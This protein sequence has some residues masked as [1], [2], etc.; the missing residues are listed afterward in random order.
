MNYIRIFTIISLLITSSAI[1]GTLIE[2]QKQNSQITEADLI[3]ESV[4]DALNQIEL[5]TEACCWTIMIYLSA[6]NDLEKYAIRDIKEMLEG[7][8]NLPACVKILVQIDRHPSNN[9]TAGYSGEALP[10]EAAEYTGARRY[11]IKNG[12]LILKESRGEVDMSKSSEL[13]NFTTWAIKQSPGCSK[14]ALI[15]WNH[16]SGDSGVGVDE[17]SG[18][19]K[20]SLKAVREALEKSKQDTN[21]SLDLL[22]FDACH[23]A[24]ASVIVEME[25]LT[26]VMVGSEEVEPGDG[27]DYKSLFKEIGKTKGDLSERT[28]GGLIVD[29][30]GKFYKSTTRKK[31]TLSS[32]DMEYVPKFKRAFRD[33]S[34]KL[35]E[36]IKND[37]IKFQIARA[38]EWARNHTYQFKGGDQIDLYHFL[39]QLSRVVDDPALLRAIDDLMNVILRMR[40]HVHRGE[41]APDATGVSIWFKKGSGFTYTYN[42]ASALKINDSSCWDPLI[43]SFDKIYKNATY[44]TWLKTNPANVSTYLEVLGKLYPKQPVQDKPDN[45]QPITN[46]DLGIDLKP[47]KDDA[48]LDGW[49]NIY[50]HIPNAKIFPYPVHTIPIENV[51]SFTGTYTYQPSTSGWYQLAM[52]YVPRN[53]SSIENVFGNG[54]NLW[55]SDQF[56]V[57]P[58]SYNLV[59]Y[60]SSSYWGRLCLVLC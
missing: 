6:D 5:D 37:T 44:R 49:I 29:T 43:S 20:L 7:S 51:S 33:F 50:E 21:Q 11:E 28:L 19:R 39:K 1:T 57:A 48:V 60:P 16:G 22:G 52:E 8:K 13:R 38:I 15:I 9:L 56:Y 14:K 40:N 36:M 41:K 24:A 31:T 45:P 23:M 26:K 55:Y 27:W 34:K 18:K 4:D 46:F 53:V 59:G 12:T 25:G 3:A 35:C 54:L 10:G 2:D 32:I 17:T 30:F 58:Q 42:G 47:I